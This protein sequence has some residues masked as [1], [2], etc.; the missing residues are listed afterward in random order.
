MDRSPISFSYDDNQYAKC[1]LLSQIVFEK[2]S[3]LYTTIVLV[4]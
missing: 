3:S 4:F 2:S 1:A